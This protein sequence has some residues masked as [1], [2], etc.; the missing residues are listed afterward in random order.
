M[1]QDGIQGIEEWFS[2]DL[3]HVC[4]KVQRFRILHNLKRDQEDPQI[5]LRVLRKQPEKTLPANP[6]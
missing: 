2:R 1:Y 5:I 3:R 6:G 4:G